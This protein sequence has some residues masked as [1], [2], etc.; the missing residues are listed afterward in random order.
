MTMDLCVDSRNIADEYKGLPEEEIKA[1]LDTVRF[2]YAVAMGQFEGDFN[3]GCVIR[4]ANAFG[5][6]QV[7]YIGKKNWDRRSAVGTHH[8][9]DLIHYDTWLD[10]YNERLYD[11]CFIAIENNVDDSVSLDEFDWGQVHLHDGPVCILLG[12][13]QNGL[14]DDALEIADYIVSIPQIGSVRSLNVA[15][16]GS[17]VMYSLMSSLKEL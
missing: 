2:P 1:R 13:E 16:A 6:E 4:S 17:I 5:A 7:F 3:F 9:I 12:E 15:V 8:Y 14:G 10:F 11:Y